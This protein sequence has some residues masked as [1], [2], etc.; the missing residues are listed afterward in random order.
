MANGSRWA[1]LRYR[2]IRQGTCWVRRRFASNAAAKCGW[3]RAIT[4]SRPILPARRSSRCAATRSSPNR[5][6][7]CP[8]SAGPRWRRSLARCTSGGAPTAKRAGPACLFA[9]PLGKAQRVLAML[10][11]ASIGPI[12]AHGAVESYSAPLPR[13]GHRASGDERA[14]EG[15]A[16][17][18]AALGHGVAVAEALRAISTAMASGWMRIRGARRRRSLDRGFVLS[19]H[20][21]WPALLTRHRRN[22]R[23]NRVGDA[24]ISRA[25]G[26]LARRA[27][28]R[29]S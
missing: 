4:N 29:A 15:R 17:A 21:D 5:P 9:Y 12:C 19:D 22:A 7:R 23:R 16:G 2:C 11:G 6:S 28:P 1:M 3:F 26:A 18:R 10:D 24:R 25:A 14:G 20:A 13:A 27:R 8:S